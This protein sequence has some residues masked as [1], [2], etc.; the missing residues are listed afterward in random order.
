M[1]F[2]E[3]I[4]K[5]AQLFTSVL[6][7]FLSLLHMQH[8]IRKILK[9][10]SGNNDYMT[11]NDFLECYTSDERLEELHS[12]LDDLK[13]ASSGTGLAFPVIFLINSICLL[14]NLY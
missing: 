2:A 3:P 11:K 9:K 12:R 14:F 7:T 4:S 5:E 6:L 10:I 13:R 1:G 8:E